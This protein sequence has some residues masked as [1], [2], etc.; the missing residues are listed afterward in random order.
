M[1]NR[2]PDDSPKSREKRF[3]EPVNTATCD[4]GL[5]ALCIVVAS[6][7]VSRAASANCRLSPWCSEAAIDGRYCKNK[8]Y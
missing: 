8:L 3:S 4:G 2:I 6:F 1:T 7:Q 5:I